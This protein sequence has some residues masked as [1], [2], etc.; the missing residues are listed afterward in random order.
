[1]TKEEMAN[2]NRVFSHVIKK[3]VDPVVEKNAEGSRYEY[4]PELRKLEHKQMVIV[5]WK[6]EEIVGMLAVGFNDKCTKDLD[7]LDRYIQ[8]EIEN[9]IN[10]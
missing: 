7:L 9:E 2:M 8:E 1:M 5:I 6:G 3:N 4:C 10:K